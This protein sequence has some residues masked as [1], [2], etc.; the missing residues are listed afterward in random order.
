MNGGGRRRIFGP[1]TTARKDRDEDLILFREMRKREKERNTSLLHPVSDDFDPSNAGFAGGNYTLYKMPSV[2]RG[3][4]HEFLSID[5]DKNDYDWL[6]T[7]PATPLFPSLE[8]EASCTNLVVQREIPILQPLKPSR[9][10]KKSETPKP[11]MISTSRPKTPTSVH[12]KAM[13]TT[14]SSRSVPPVNP[15]PGAS[16]SR[17][18][19]QPKLNSSNPVK[20]SNTDAKPRS[21]GVSPMVRPRIPHHDFPDEAPLN[22]ITSATAVSSRPSSATRGRPGDPIVRREMPENPRRQSCSPSVT[23]GRRVPEFVGGGSAKNGALVVG[24]RMVE[25]VMNARRL[26]GGGGGGGDK[27]SKLKCERDHVDLKRMV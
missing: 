17:T 10:A 26:V 2:K 15:R 20:K 9:F 27:G 23:R 16:I 19:Q 1:P 21:R 22:L 5:G 7:P 18:T 8:M 25:R 3:I 24:S 14:I 13:T 11:M 4:G 6:K 12:P